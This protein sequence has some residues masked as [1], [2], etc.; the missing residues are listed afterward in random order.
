MNKTGFS[1]QLQ[2]MT[3]GCRG[4]QQSLHIQMGSA[5][6]QTSARLLSTMRG[7]H[8]LASRTQNSA[9]LSSGC[10]RLCLSGPRRICRAAPCRSVRMLCTG[11]PQETQRFSSLI[12]DLAPAHFVDHVALLLQMLV[13]RARDAWD[14]QGHTGRQKTHRTCRNGEPLAR[15]SRTCLNTDMQWYLCVESSVVDA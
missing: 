6:Q 13:P 5:H 8:C 7:W 15:L 10:L 4:T 11:P 1:V 2:G 9:E 12:Q 14:A 3:H